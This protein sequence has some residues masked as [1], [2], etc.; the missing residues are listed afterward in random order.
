MT[1]TDIYPLRAGAYAGDMK[2]T[3]AGRQEVPAVTTSASG[4][5]HE[6]TA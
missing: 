1:V 2:V 6:V 3:L 5:H 4:T